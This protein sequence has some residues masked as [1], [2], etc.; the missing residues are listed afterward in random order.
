MDYIHN[1]RDSLVAQYVL[2]RISKIYNQIMVTKENKN[3]LD[4]AHTYK[5]SRLPH[6]KDRTKIDII[7]FQ[8]QKRM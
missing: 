4:D 7:S 6:M 8:P 2:R 5:R 1:N 3:K